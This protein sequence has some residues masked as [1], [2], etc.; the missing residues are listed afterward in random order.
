MSRT[1]AYVLAASFASIPL[2]IGANAAP[3]IID[4]YYE[5]TVGIGDCALDISFACTVPF[6]KVRSGKKL[7][8]TRV[9]CH[10]GVQGPH[11]QAVE[12]ALFILNPKG[13]WERKQPLT[14]AYIG[15]TSDPDTNF[16]GFNTQTFTVLTQGRTPIVWW[17]TFDGTN[18]S[19]DCQIAGE[20]VPYP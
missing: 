9:A 14:S 5:E 17:R 1:A 18:V 3:V 10:M 19:M 20:I 6:S 2:A 7:T 12:A 16:Y 11:R 4:A 13:A 8:I 15:F